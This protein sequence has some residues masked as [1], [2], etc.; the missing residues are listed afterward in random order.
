VSWLQTFKDRLVEVIDQA[1]HFAAIGM[2]GG[3]SA[4]GDAAAAFR[5]GL[6]GTERERESYCTLCGRR[7]I[8]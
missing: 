1:Q 6:D 5:E 8:C 2:S 7:L 4:T 3:G